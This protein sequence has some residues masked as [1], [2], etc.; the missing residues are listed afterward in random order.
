MTVTTPCPV[1]NAPTIIAQDASGA[2]LVL[3][4]SAKVYGAEF[5]FED[6]VQFYVRLTKGE[7]LVEHRA[8]C[9][10]ADGRR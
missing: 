5:D 2:R 6:R 4:A 1:C 7:A 8:V 10:P 3:D 9:R